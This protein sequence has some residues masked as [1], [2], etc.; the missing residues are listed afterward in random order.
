MLQ[1]TLFLA[2]RYPMMAERQVIIVKE[3]QDLT[4]TIDKLE[5]YAE[6]PI[7]PLFW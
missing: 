1:K 2:K 7:R 5:S 6:N 3:A 4:R